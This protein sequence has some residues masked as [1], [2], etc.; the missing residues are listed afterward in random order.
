MARFLRRKALGRR[1]EFDHVKQIWSIGIFEGDSLKKLRPAEGVQNPVLTAADVSDVPARFVADPFMLR[2]G[3]RWSMF[4]EVWNRASHRGEIGLASSRDGRQWSYDRI[5]LAEPFHLSYPYVFQWKG[6]HY[7]IPETYETRTVRLYRAVEFPHAW[8]FTH[9]LISGMRF[10][11]ASIFRHDGA[12]WMLV[13][14]S[15]E[16]KCDVLRLYSASNLTGPWTEHSESPLAINDAR[17]A[18]PAGRVVCL[19]GKLYRFAQECVLLYGL[20][21]HLF[22]IQDLSKERYREEELPGGVP[23]NGSGSGWNHGGMHH[24]DVHEL[25]DGGLLACVDGWVDSRFEVRKS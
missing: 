11:D 4:F 16:L 25:P 21:V 20:R 10:K 2:E 23:L 3:E 13:E 24:I 12:W 8:E 1:A 9:T 22:E 7:M 18:R 6:E 14:T 5:V 19:G 17:V 15:P